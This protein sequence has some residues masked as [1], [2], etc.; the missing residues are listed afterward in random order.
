MMISWLWFGFALYSAFLILH[1]K[2]FIKLI[3]FLY[4]SAFCIIWP[5]YFRPH[6]T[7]NFVLL[8]NKPTEALLS[9]GW[10]FI[11]MVIYSL[12]NSTYVPNFFC[13]FW[14]EMSLTQRVQTYFNLHI[15]KKDIFSFQNINNL[16]VKTTFLAV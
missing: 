12:Y 13:D 15:L 6:I 11:S 9:Q 4:H 7:F 16:V 8:F 3:V 14:K 2:I 10:R 5:F 1:Y